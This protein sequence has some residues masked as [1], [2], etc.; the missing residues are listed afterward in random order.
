MFK[1]GNFPAC[2][3]GKRGIDF[4]QYHAWLGSR[5][6]QDL[7]PWRHD[8]AVAIGLATIHMGS[9]LRWRDHESAILDGAGPQQHMPVCFSGRHREG[10]RD[11]ESESA[12]PGQPPIE[13]WE[14][15][16]ITDRY[17]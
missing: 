7:A 13:F 11:R 10:R 15:Q 12:F 6:G 3:R 8:Q 1:I 17:A 5:F 9:T 4:R 14:A 16:V 2:F